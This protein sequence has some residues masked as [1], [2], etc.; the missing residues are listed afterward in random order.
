MSCDNNNSCDCEYTHDYIT[1]GVSTTA[2]GIIRCLT[3][4][5]ETYTSAMET[6]CSSVKSFGF[7]V[8]WMYCTAT[9]YLENKWKYCYDTCETIRNGID[10][11]NENLNAIL[12][13]TSKIPTSKNWSQVCALIH[14][15]ADNPPLYYESFRCLGDDISQDDAQSHFKDAYDSLQDANDAMVVM[16]YQD[17]YRVKWY[18][19]F[20]KN[21]I[22]ENESPEKSLFEPISVTFNYADGKE[23]DLDIP[24]SMWSV[25]NEL[26]TP[27]FVRRCLKHQDISFDDSMNY[28]IEIMDVDVNI[29]QVKSSEFIE[30]GQNSIVI[31]TIPAREMNELDC[32]SDEKE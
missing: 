16:K 10:I 29:Y 8:F 7:R 17:V 28:T 26:F 20:C 9:V 14:I 5:D 23:I 21:T 32:S 27:V 31:R 24:A 22:H 6:I 11:F 25:G 13:K 1:H 19:P 30:V 3:W 2:Y 4:I 18:N 12:G 15:D